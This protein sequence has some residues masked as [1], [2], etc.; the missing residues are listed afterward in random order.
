M[1]NCKALLQHVCD[2]NEAVDF[3]LL[4]DLLHE[5]LSEV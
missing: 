1:T 2:K 4:I 3:F 5:S